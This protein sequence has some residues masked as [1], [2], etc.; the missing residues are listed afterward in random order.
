MTIGLEFWPTFILAILGTWRI[1]HM[2]SNEDGPGD[3]IARFRTFLGTGLAG[4][5][6]DCFYCLS[7]WVAFPMTL[8]VTREA[9]QFLLT[10]LALSG[11]ACILNRT[12][13]ESMIMQ[14]NNQKFGGDP[15]NG[16]LRPET[17]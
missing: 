7:L 1:T 15:K 11:S 12:T 10:W 16:M 5:L 2:L 4:K 13:Q 14:S 17:G 8:F 3:L 6:M 9:F